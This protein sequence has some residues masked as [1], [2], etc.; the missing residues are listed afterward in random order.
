MRVLFVQRIHDIYVKTEL[1][2]VG[3]MN[4][5][6]GNV[7]FQFIDYQCKDAPCESILQDR[8]LN[9]TFT[10]LHKALNVY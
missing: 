6:N 5:N 7:F 8:K 2:P 3:N 9:R 10:N 4:D 1:E